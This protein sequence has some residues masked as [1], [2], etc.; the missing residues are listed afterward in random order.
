[1]NAQHLKLMASTVACLAIASVLVGAP[2][3]LWFCR[4]TNGDGNATVPDGAAGGSAIQ[5]GGGCF[6]VG[7]YRSGGAL[8]AEHMETRFLSSPIG[9]SPGSS[10]RTARRSSHGNRS[11]PTKSSPPCEPTSRTRVGSPS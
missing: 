8:S 9:G 7:C 11:T 3:H 5:G 2:P 10:S 1:M 4:D 6:G